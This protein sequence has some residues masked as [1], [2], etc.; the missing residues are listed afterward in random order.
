MSWLPPWLRGASNK[1][2]GDYIVMR[3]IDAK[4]AFLLDTSDAIISLYRGPYEDS[5]QR[6]LN[7][8]SGSERRL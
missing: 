7:T 2:F 3:F 6:F 4:L 1:M 5:V 8:L